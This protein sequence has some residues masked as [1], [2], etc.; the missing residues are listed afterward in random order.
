MLDKIFVQLSLKT[1][2]ALVT[3][4]IFVSSLW[5][6]SYFA[7]WM[8]QSD[9]KRLL[10]EQ[11]AATA[12][13]AAE[14]VKGGLLNRIK[15]LE[16]IAQSIDASMFDRPEELNKTLDQNLILHAI[17][18]AGV[19]G[20]NK[21]GAAIV[22]S[23][24]SIERIGVNY[25]DRDYLIGALKNGKPTIG[26][27]VI[28]RILK[29]PVFIVAVPILNTGGEVIGALAGVTSLNEPNFLDT[30]RG[31][32]Y[33]RTGGFS[34]FDSKS[35]RIVTASDKSLIMTE[36][37]QP[38]DDPVIDRLLQGFEGAE[39]YTN[40]FGKVELATARPISTEGWF[41]AVMLPIDEAFTPIEEM[42]RNMMWATLFLTL[43][44]GVV[45][46]LALRR[47]LRP[48]LETSK[49]L[50]L[51]AESN[52]PPC[53]LPIFSQDEIGQVIGGFN[54]LLSSYSKNETALR[55]SEKQYRELYNDVPVGYHEYDLQGRITRVNQTELTLTGYC[56]DEV[57][58]HFVWEFVADEEESKKRTLG[59]L[60]KSYPLNN[61]NERELSCKDGTK[62]PALFQDKTCLDEAGNITGIRTIMLPIADRK[63]AEAA[64]MRSEARYRAIFETSQEIISI[65]RV[66]D[67]VYLEANQAFFAT[68][69]LSPSEVV[70]RTSLELNLWVDLD[71]KQ[72]VLELLKT[73]GS[74]SNHEF[75][76]RKASGEI[77]WAL[78][79]A[80]V[81]ELDGEACVVF[82]RSDITER[83]G[84]EEKINYLAFYDQLTG[85]PN[86][87][88]LQDRIKQAMA[89]NH[90]SGLY[91]ALLL[92]DLDHFK[93]LNDT[94]GHDMGDILLKQVADRLIKC[95]REE[96]TVARLGGDEFVVMLSG[97]SSCPN[98]TE[99][100]IELIAEKINAALEPP[101]DINGN[102]YRTSSSIGAS[103][104]YGHDTEIDS[105]LKQ[106]DLAM[107]KA[108][109]TGRN[110]LRFFDP[111]MA[112]DVIKR[113]TL[114]TDLREA[115]Q[116]KQFLLHYQ[117]QVC[118]NQIV[119]AE[120]LLRWN[121]PE[122]GLVPP[123][124]FITAIEDSGLI[125]S[126]GK[127]VLENACNQ[128]VRWAVDGKSHLT[129]AVN[130]S[131]R[132]L[133]DEG[134]VDLVLAT[135][136]QTRANPFRLKLELTES[137]LVKNV[138]QIIGKMNALKSIGVGF[139]LDVLE[140]AILRSP[141]SS[142]YL[143]TN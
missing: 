115:V 121:H 54:Q 32:R 90:R 103:V 35:R 67:G 106:A 55:A 128:L 95:V 25:L 100:S 118:V 102:N 18:N 139:S 31:S 93:T 33:G 28:G 4:A 80:S 72:A 44:A 127:W 23:P 83:K 1:K 73:K 17:F 34:I 123:S 122:R 112:K 86:R 26:K 91:G 50:S 36:F 99:S 57:L 37:P 53:P 119:G 78:V 38:G 85:L 65:C 8:L 94:L 89:K 120:I 29:S 92:L 97:L 48:L 19:I 108:K 58:G 130:I 51:L 47:Q 104:F 134:F 142:V 96:D 30:I 6:L 140:R 98:E 52:Q 107:Y 11:Q 59:K 109:E 129:I 15:A 70:G 24:Q 64:L 125:L 74:L 66:S 114:E 133:N 12:S 9:M 45:T 60:S 124:H 116:Q 39:L 135:L 126:V 27:P 14:E 41:I 138:E 82:V 16:L 79:S 7:I 88:L 49:A 61:N 5:A 136:E 75:R 63:L 69:G 111:G 2:I 20:F 131:A 42:K 22:S 113:A 143:S 56:E 10:G 105:L 43:V 117:P 81:I 71:E 13:Y 137:L 62:I 101:F 77:F 141:I 76:F 3:L 21:E 84:S 46:W 87:T 40:Q 110:K 132:Q 68:L